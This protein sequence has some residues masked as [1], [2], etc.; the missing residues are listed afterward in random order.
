MRYSSGEG[1]YRAHVPVDLA[2]REINRLG[3]R[4]GEGGSVRCLDLACQPRPG[5]GRHCPAC[6]VFPSGMGEGALAR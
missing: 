5:P 6:C 3:V 2:C 4:I 1:H